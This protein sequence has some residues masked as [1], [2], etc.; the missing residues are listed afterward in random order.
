MHTRN[1]SRDLRL[2]H[3]ALHSLPDASE[4]SVTCEQGAV[5]LTVDGNPRDFVLKA[6]ETFETSDR[7]R[8]L[9]YALADSRISLREAMPA[10]QP[11]PWYGLRLPARLSAGHA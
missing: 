10:P 1:L 3:K 7:G 2:A 5:W 11:A 8:L 9:I 4:L 6:G